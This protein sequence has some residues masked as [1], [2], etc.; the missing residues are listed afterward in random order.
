M[1]CGGHFNGGT[2]IGKIANSDHLD[3]SIFAWLRKG[4]VAVVT[5]EVS[6]ELVGA[7]WLEVAMDNVGPEDMT[8]SPSDM[9]GDG[10]KMM[11]CERGD[12]GF[13]AE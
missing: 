1:V 8:V 13:T 5:P 9:E 7:V 12:L 2:A 4:I 6:L 3:A 10:A 11:G